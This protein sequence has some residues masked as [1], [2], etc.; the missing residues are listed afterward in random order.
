MGLHLAAVDVDP[1]CQTLALWTDLDEEAVS[2]RYTVPAVSKVMSWYPYVLA[3]THLLEY[4]LHERLAEGEIHLNDLHTYNVLTRYLAAWQRHSY[5]NSQNVPVPHRALLEHWSQLISQLPGWRLKL[6][7]QG[8][9]Q[10]SHPLRL[11]H[12]ALSTAP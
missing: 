3:L 11:C 12:T 9:E 6:F 5:H 4:I 10:L 7:T 2:V 8:Y 1:S